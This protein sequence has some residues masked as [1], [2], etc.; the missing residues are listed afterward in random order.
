MGIF[1]TREIRAA[2]AID[3]LI[4]LPEDD[5]ASRLKSAIIVAIVAN[6]AVFSIAFFASILHKSDGLRLSKLSCWRRPLMTFP[7]S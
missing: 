2:G 7:A 6:V 1:N 4:R 3:H 5:V